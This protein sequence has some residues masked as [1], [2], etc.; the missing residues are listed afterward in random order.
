MLNVPVAVVKQRE[1]ERTEGR[2]TQG[3]TSGGASSGMSY[4][5]CLS[6]HGAALPHDNVS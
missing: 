5:M 6:A 1:A 3:A 4:Y 2:R